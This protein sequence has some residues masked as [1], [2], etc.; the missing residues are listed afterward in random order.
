MG[1]KKLPSLPLNIE[2]TRVNLS[3]HPWCHPTCLSSRSG[4]RRCRAGRKT[5]FFMVLLCVGTSHPTYLLLWF[6]LVYKS[7]LRSAAHECVLERRIPFR[8]LTNHR[9]AVG[10][11]SRTLSLNADQYLGQTREGLIELA[12]RIAAGSENVNFLII[13]FRVYSL[14]IF[15][16]DKLHQA[17]VSD[18][19]HRLPP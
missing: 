15:Y 14:T 4:L 8:T 1:T 7:F 18:S 12:L 11:L 17:P 13:Y 5:S 19:A 9:I 2:G 10:C 6:S 3:S 16:E